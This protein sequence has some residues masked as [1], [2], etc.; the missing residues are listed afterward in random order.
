MLSGGWRHTPR[1]LYYPAIL[2]VNIW[3]FISAKQFT[4]STVESR[5]KHVCVLAILVQFE[6]KT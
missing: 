2:S 1:S 4:C 6:S 3:H 5:N